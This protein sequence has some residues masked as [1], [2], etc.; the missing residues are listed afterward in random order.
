VR[1]TLL[2]V[3]LLAMLAAGCGGSD[4]SG[5]DLNP[6]TLVLGPADVPGFVVDEALTGPVANEEVAR[7]REQ[8]YEEKL[9]DW[10][11]IGGFSRQLRREGKAGPGVRTADGLNSVASVY[12]DEDGA[13]ESFATG[14]QDYAEA[15]FA[16]EGDLD[17]GDEGRLFRGTDGKRQVEYLIATWRRGEVIASVVVEARPERVGFATLREL[18][19]EQDERIAAALEE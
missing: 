1:A 10:G 12:E 15:G 7:G 2:I 8:G 19:R 13:E 11:R 4:S 16:R 18:A 5:E 3:C 9:E 6:R 14:V 17:L